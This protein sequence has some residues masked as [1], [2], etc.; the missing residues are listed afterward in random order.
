MLPFDDHHDVANNIISCLDYAVSLDGLTRAGAPV[1]N[2]SHSASLLASRKYASSNFEVKPLDKLCLA[3]N[4]FE[5]RQE[6]CRRL[7]RTISL[8]V[9]GRTSAVSTHGWHL[10]QLVEPTMI[11]ETPRQQLLQPYTPNS[12]ISS[13]ST[14]IMV[15]RVMTPCT[16][17]AKRSP[18]CEATRAKAEAF[19]RIE[20]TTFQTE[21]PGATTT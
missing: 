19:E 14:S 1:N 4:S 5:S 8:R 10:E 7:T 2:L 11:A 21:S 6:G 16:L 18:S 20:A 3:G 9:R 12:S 15:L 17:E 13:A